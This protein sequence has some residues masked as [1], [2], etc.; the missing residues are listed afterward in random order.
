MKLHNV[1]LDP[2]CYVASNCT[3]IGDVTVGK[4]ASIFPGA[5]VRAEYE[6][7]TIGR[8]SNI[9]DNVVIHVDEGFPTV[10]GEGVTVGHGA[11]IHGC[12]IK[13]NCLIGMGSVIMNGAIIGANS[14]IGAG[15]VVA[16]GAHIPENSLVIGLPAKVKRATTEEEVAFN[17]YAATEYAEGA[18]AYHKEGIFLL[19]S[20]VHLGHPSI[21]LK[22]S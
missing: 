17:R 5:V 20:E 2:Q 8:R 15:A 12:T 1:H 19:G 16:Q 3:L 21:F 4:G 10:I 14:V 7:V 9:Q 6:P 13:D 11:I 22:R 18:L